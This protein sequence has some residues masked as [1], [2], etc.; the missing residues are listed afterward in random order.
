MAKDDGAARQNSGDFTPERA[1]KTIAALHDAIQAAKVPRASERAN[2]EA[3]ERLACLL[4]QAYNQLLVRAVAADGEHDTRIRF[5]VVQALDIYET[6]IAEMGLRR[7]G[8]GS[9]SL[10]S[11]ELATALAERPMSTVKVL[12]NAAGACSGLIA[13]VCRALAGL[14]HTGGPG[15][16]GD[17]GV[18]FERHPTEGG[19]QSG[20]PGQRAGGTPRVWV[21]EASAPKVSIA[22]FQP[23]PY[24]IRD[25]EKPPTPGERPEFYA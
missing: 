16:S 12:R 19:P 6:A 9:L 18:T 3:A 23:S 5:D 25:E 17:L 15:P 14:N 20:A 11:A 21:P 8:E 22:S 10:W 7:G 1:I 24:G 4:I 13:F 2:S